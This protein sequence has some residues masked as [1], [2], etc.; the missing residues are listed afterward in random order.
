MLIFSVGIAEKKM[1]M[2][3]IDVA[4]LLK[5]GEFGSMEGGE[6]SKCWRG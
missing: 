6:E 2:R 1:D 4:N 3:S 5:V